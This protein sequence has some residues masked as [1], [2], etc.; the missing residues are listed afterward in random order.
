[1]VTNL[2]NVLL[3]GDNQIK[4]AWCNESKDY[5]MTDSQSFKGQNHA[6]GT[7]Q[8][9]KFVGQGC[10]LLRDLTHSHSIKEDTI[11]I[12]GIGLYP[13]NQPAVN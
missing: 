6:S 1:M 3:H 8:P 5:L 12:N 11:A 2:C 9:K 13:D 7:N 4:I 10:Q